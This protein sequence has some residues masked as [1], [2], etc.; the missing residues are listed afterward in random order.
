MK[1]NLVI[2][3]VSL[4]LAGSVFGNVQN[5][6]IDDGQ[7]SVAKNGAVGNWAGHD[8]LGQGGADQRT[9][10]GTY[11]GD[12]WDLEAFELVNG[13]QLGVVGTFDLKNGLN[14][15]G[16]HIASG[17]IFLNT[18]GPIS[19]NNLTGWDYVI[20]VNWAGGTY[21]VYANPSPA[22]M[23]QV[24]ALAP[25]SNP[26]TYVPQA[27]DVSI[28]SGNYVYTTA[29][30]QGFL[31]DALN[32]THNLALFDLS[33]LTDNTTFVSHFTMTCGNDLIAGQGTKVGGNGGPP[34]GV[35]D[36]GT[37]LILLGLAFTGL[38]VVDRR[39]RK[40]RLS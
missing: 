8:G 20:H 36:S 13:N 16:D 27:G 22:G 19:G 32:A 38:T 30:D 21:Q 11:T 25:Q 5:I 39:I 7:S 6:T 23:T 24:T 31:S 12:I 26:F 37:T 3:A 1:L 33:F 17:D 34:A 28:E 35:P 9:M 4:S 40:I 18:S 10:P 29:N 2:A 14:F 15:N